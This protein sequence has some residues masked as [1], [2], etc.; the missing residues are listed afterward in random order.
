MHYKLVDHQK[1]LF[2]LD[3]S[4]NRFETVTAL[5]LIIEMREI[6]RKLTRCSAF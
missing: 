6:L 5:T 4:L 1:Y 3:A 2:I